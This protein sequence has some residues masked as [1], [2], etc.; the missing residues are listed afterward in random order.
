MKKNN[1]RF[2]EIYNSFTFTEKSEFKEFISISLFTKG[3]KYNSLLD[4]LK[5]NSAGHV[6]MCCIDNNRTFFNRLSELTN[7]AVKFLIFK[8]LERNKFASEMILLDELSFREINNFYIQKFESLEKSVSKKSMSISKINKLYSINLLYLKNSNDLNSKVKKIDTYRTNSD[9]RF[10]QFIAGNLDLMI[11]EFINN[12]NKSSDSKCNRKLLFESL[13]FNFILKYIKNNIPDY[14]PV[15]SF[16]YNVYMAIKNVEES[17][18]YSDAKNILM[19]ELNDVSDDFKSKLLEYLI[20][21]Q[22]LKMNINKQAGSEELFF[23]TNEKIK[24]KSFEDELKSD[25]NN[26]R[27]ISYINNALALGK[28]EWAEEFINKFGEFLPRKTRNNG[29]FLSKAFLEFYRKDFKACW[30]FAEKID[31]TNIYYYVFSSYI[32]MQASY[33]LKR[34]EECYLILKRFKEFLRTKPESDKFLFNFAHR[35]CVC[36]AL[37]LKFYENP[38]PKNFQN[39][40]YELVQN[41]KIESK[42]IKMKLNE[43][44]LD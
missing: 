39:L 7:L 42:W 44:D 33:E 22:I 14:Y 2:F 25:L 11:T 38:N 13:D 26:S 32:K 5:L 27:F 20:K 36:F 34:T 12:C 15:V 10:I 28:F 4:N 16:Y 18:Y 21:Y 37:L 29:I 17:H 31:I 23:L 8:N 35:F 41:E 9:L 43:I 1:T 40:E 6:K 3:R 19:N 24:C 30:E